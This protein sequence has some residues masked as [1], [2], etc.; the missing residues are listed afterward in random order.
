M[1]GILRRYE[2]SLLDADLKIENR[3]SRVLNGRTNGLK[4]SS[5]PEN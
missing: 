4:H 5:V 2:K 1:G 3:K